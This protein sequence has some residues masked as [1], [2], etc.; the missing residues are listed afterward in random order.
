MRAK[1]SKDFTFSASHRLDG[2]PPDHQCARHHGHNYTVRLIVS[3]EVTEPG[4]V[5]DYGELKPF[6]QWIDATLDHRYLNDI[7]EV[8]RYGN[9][10]AEN[11]AQMLLH[12]AGELIPALIYHVVSVSVSET[13][14]TW[15][16]VGGA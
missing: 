9:P 10:T 13:P 2:L 15:A 4:F 12:K 3:G 1:I 8:R 16:T 6:G 11:L 5:I 14:K 7:A